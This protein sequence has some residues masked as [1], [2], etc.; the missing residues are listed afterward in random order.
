MLFDIPLDVRKVIWQ[1]VRE[2]H[3]SDQQAR[4]LQQIQYDL[5]D[6]YELQNQYLYNTSEVYV[7]H[8]FSE[9]SLF[10]MAG[11]LTAELFF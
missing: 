1:K 6:L 5:D 7:L 4:L 2:L 8:K 10:F 3:E 9:I 11:F